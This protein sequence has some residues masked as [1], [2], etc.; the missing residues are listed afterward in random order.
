VV[1]TV[2]W[3]FAD[4]IRTDYPEAEREIYWFLLGFMGFLVLVGI[5]VAIRAIDG[6]IRLGLGA[7]DLGKHVTVEG[8]VVNR[9]LGRIAID[10]G[11]DDETRAWTPPIG[12]P[13]L[14]RGMLIRATMSPRLCHVT[15]IEVLGEAT[16]QL[17]HITALAPD[18][19]AEPR[20]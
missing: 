16:P 13:A 5:V 18:P 19:I 9:Y 10:N 20:A 6:A 1:A 7:L 2:V 17:D 14:H 12:A 15:N 4:E 3:D 11:I 8:E